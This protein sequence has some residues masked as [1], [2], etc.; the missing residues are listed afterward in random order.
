M[1]HLAL[2]LCGKMEGEEDLDTADAHDDATFCILP[3][4]SNGQNS[5]GTQLHLKVST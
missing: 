3:T 5:N 2:L 4:A 1:E